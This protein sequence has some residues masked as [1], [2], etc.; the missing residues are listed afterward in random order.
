MPLLT[1][2]INFSIDFYD[3]VMAVHCH[4]GTLELCMLETAEEE[5]D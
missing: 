1:L 3:S 2:D 4:G 5:V